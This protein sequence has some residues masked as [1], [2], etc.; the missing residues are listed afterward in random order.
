MAKLT[1]DEVIASVLNK[2]DEGSFV[3]ADVIK[4]LNQ[5]NVHIA[6]ELYIKELSTVSEITIS[7]DANTASLPSDFL[8]GFVFAYNSTIGRPVK[9]YDSR[10]LVDRKLRGIRTSGDVRYACNDYPNVY[11]AYAPA[12]DQLLDI[13][14]CKLPTDLEIG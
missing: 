11:V 5:C 7:A 12:G 6:T 13:Y 4:T 3:A 9:V 14:Y 1:V 8:R 2:V 10:R